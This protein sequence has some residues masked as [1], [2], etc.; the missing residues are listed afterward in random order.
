MNTNGYVV[1]SDIN[2]ALVLCTDGKFHA[3]SQVGPGGYCA[4][5]YLT[6]AGARKHNPGRITEEIVNGAP[7]K[8]H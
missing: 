6:E 8:G 5:V 1:R 3:E 2:P 4:K 7:T